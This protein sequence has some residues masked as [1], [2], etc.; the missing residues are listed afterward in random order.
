MILIYCQFFRYG[1]HYFYAPVVKGD[2]IWI[3]WYEIDATQMMSLHWG[4]R[5][6]SQ[7]WK[8]GPYQSIQPTWNYDVKSL[9]WLLC[10]D[11]CCQRILWWEMINDV[12]F[13]FSKSLECWPNNSFNIPLT[14]IWVR[15]VPTNIG[16]DIFFC[17][18][19]ISVSCLLCAGV[20]FS[21]DKPGRNTQT[22]RRTRR[23]QAIDTTN[24]TT[25]Q[26]PTR[27]SYFGDLALST[28]RG[29]TLIYSLR[30]R[31]ITRK[32]PQHKHI[33]DRR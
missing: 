33:P 24:G 4:V 23:E 27:H 6:P 8:S 9:Q 13:L 2:S 21:C 29:A 14:K 1:I 31:S 19:V 22:N 10:P 30:P 28:T 15:F 7:K 11:S 26:L 20:L 32:R 17:L 5:P 12:K 16:H 25:H 3:L 18:V